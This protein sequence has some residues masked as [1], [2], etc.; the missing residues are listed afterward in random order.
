MLAEKYNTTTG[1]IRK[2]GEAGKLTGSDVEWV[3][4]KMTG[5]GGL[6]ENAMC[7][8][9]TTVW[10]LWSTMKDTVNEVLMGVGQSAIDSLAVKEMIT[11]V[12]TFA[13][14]YRGQVVSTIE[15]GFD[16]ILAI[17]K[18]VA[19][20]LSSLDPG[21][22]IYWTK[23]AA[24]VTLAVFAL[25]K[26]LSIASG[27]ISVIQFMN[28]AFW[29]LQAAA[30]A[31]AGPI[32][33]LATVLGVLVAIPVAITLGYWIKAYLD[34]NTAISKSIDLSAQLNALQDKRANAVLAT[35]EGKTGQEK[36]DYLKAEYEQ[37]KVEMA[38]LEKMR[39]EAAATLREKA[40]WDA[41]YFSPA[42]LAGA[43]RQ[44]T[45][46]LTVYRAELDTA[47]KSLEDQAERVAELRKAIEAAGAPAAAKTVEETAAPMGERLT[48]KEGMS[49]MEAE[50]LRFKAAA[51]EGKAMMDQYMT[52]KEKFDKQMK[53]INRLEK[54][55]GPYSPP[56]PTCQAGR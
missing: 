33:G 6:F 30:I 19:S 55:L 29:G 49:P 38:G 35:A 36:T 21:A 23:M 53:D 15:K 26:I 22:I 20:W 18:R 25:G 39:N 43:Y 56:L 34:L 3:F 28:T 8:Q 11:A 9:A 12:T 32:G 16:E 45:G 46:G 7:K 14:K 41:D 13:E 1:E 31:V 37:A 17:G 42:D 40:G 44:A 2:M 24:G 51:D 47:E 27:V 54:T 4:K 10:G 50:L 52:N 48:G 5:S